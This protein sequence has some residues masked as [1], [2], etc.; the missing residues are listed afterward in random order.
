MAREVDELMYNRDHSLWADEM[1]EEEE[2]GMILDISSWIEVHL[3]DLS[4]AW[5]EIRDFREETGN[6]LFD[7]S[8]FNDFCE[9][10]YSVST[11]TRFA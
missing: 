9:A 2:E 3:D 10:M 1:D 11:K 7:A 8:D 5:W 4:D 6:V